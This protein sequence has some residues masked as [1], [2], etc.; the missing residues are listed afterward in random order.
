MFTTSMENS[1]FLTLT[2]NV[3]DI[4]LSVL[5]STKKEKILLQCVPTR[6]CNLIGATKN[7]PFIIR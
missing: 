7:R 3:T 1:V 6:Q 2:A 4:V 5:Y